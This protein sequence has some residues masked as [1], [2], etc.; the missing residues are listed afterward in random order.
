MQSVHRWSDR[1][2]NFPWLDSI[3]S[4]KHILCIARAVIS[5]YTGALIECRRASDNAVI[6]I[7]Q[8]ADRKLDVAAI[9]A[10]CGAS[11]G[12]VT[13]VYDQS[14]NGIT[15]SEGTAANQPQIWD[16]TAGKPLR[17]KSSDGT[18]IA[19]FWDGTNDALRSNS[20]SVG[21]GNPALTVVATA[22]DVGDN[23]C[24]F[25]IGD[26]TNALR[27][28]RMF[29]GASNTMAIDAAS[30]SFQQF[31]LEDITAP[32]WYQTSK[33]AG[34]G[35]D[36]WVQRQDGR[37]LTPIGGSGANALAITA[38]D[39]SDWCCR[40]SG[41]NA[42]AGQLRARSNFY[43]VWGAVL[44]TEEQALIDRAMRQLLYGHSRP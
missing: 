22:C 40:H 15:H 6:D 16:G 33:A 44:S 30:T 13:K 36:A 32:H 8:R 43:G 4:P 24:L 21:T 5:T 10:H 25:D 29:F 41:T 2:V 37:V 23:D 18:G 35:V 11:N 39:R 7:G 9:A 19:A 12:Y 20:A 38:G 3:S 34:V 31:A 28:M 42:T 17:F 1:R 26:Q 14:G 27:N